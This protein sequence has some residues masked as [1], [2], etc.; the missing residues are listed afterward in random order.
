[1]DLPELK[2]DKDSQL[3]HSGGLKAIWE[4]LKAIDREIRKAVKEEDHARQKDLRAAAR[5]LLCRRPQSRREFDKQKPGFSRC[6]ECG[7]P[8][9]VSINGQE[10]PVFQRF[11]FC[12]ETPITGGACKAA[13][14][15]AHPNV[16]L[17][18]SPHSET[19]QR[20]ERRYAQPVNPHAY[21]VSI[22]PRLKDGLFVKVETRR[23]RKA[24]A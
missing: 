7:A 8:F 11:A 21:P 14:I 18:T 4:Q 9:T 10:K 3:G 15:A 1:L 12:K 20:L 23:V 22:G 5:G 6:M 13:W 24:T 17:P 19:N 16:A 2:K